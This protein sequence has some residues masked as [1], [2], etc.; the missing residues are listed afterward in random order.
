MGILAQIVP[1]LKF[2]IAELAITLQFSVRY[3]IAF[4]KI[5]N[6]ISVSYN[7]FCQLLGVNQSHTL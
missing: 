6:I 1:S 4:S 5:T 3:L 7:I 2:F